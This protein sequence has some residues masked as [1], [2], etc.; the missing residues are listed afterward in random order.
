MK[1]RGF[2]VVITCEPDFVST[3]DGDGPWS[4]FVTRPDSHDPKAEHLSLASREV[5]KASEILEKISKHTKQ[6]GILWRFWNGPL[7][8]K[9][10]SERWII[11]SN[12]EIEAQQPLYEARFTRCYL[13]HKAAIKKCQ[14]MGSWPPVPTDEWIISDD[15][16]SSN[17]Q[18][19]LPDQ[20]T[21]KAPR[22]AQALRIFDSDSPGNGSH[23]SFR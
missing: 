9:P 6:E 20:K 11:L 13:A 22:H 4:V 17:D 16:D 3:E 8:S 10:P 23:I 5:R 7:A 19:R 18:K 1:L 12:Q 14:E 15:S 21:R 2:F